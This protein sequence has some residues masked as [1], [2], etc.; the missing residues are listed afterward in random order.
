M[1][2]KR[3]CVFR[4]GST[5]F[6]FPSRLA[7]FVA[8]LYYRWHKSGDPTVKWSARAAAE[9]GGA[10]CRRDLWLDALQE[11]RVRRH[12]WLNHVDVLT[13]VLSLAQVKLGC[14]HHCS[15]VVLI[16]KHLFVRVVKKT[17]FGCM[18]FLIRQKCHHFN[19]RDCC[20]SRWARQQVCCAMWFKCGQNY[21]CRKGCIKNNLRPL[22]SAIMD[23]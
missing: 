6:R 20:G 11:V 8:C 12:I 2:F 14:Y 3:R 21:A 19:L 9:L 1:N 7:F 15:S 16:C 18:R 17:F 22:H 23:D 13:L 5:H 4:I 10:A